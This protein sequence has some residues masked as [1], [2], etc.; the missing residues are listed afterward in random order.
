MHGLLGVEEQQD[1]RPEQD[2]ELKDDADAV[3]QAS[4]PHAGADHDPGDE[5]QDDRDDDRIPRAERDAGE[6]PAEDDVDDDA[7]ERL[8][9]DHARGVE[10]GGQP[11]PPFA[12][13]VFRPL[14]DAA[15]NRVLRDQFAELQ[16]HHGLE[17]QADR[18]HPDERWPAHGERCGGHQDRSG[19]R[20]L[21]RDAEERLLQQV[22][23]ALELWLDAEFAQVGV[24]LDVL[25]RVGGCLPGCLLVHCCAP[26]RA[27]GSR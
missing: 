14:V 3:E 9:D 6:E 4:Q 25:G 24:V 2:D 5:R 12:A 19:G 21:E 26:H 20:A 8:D 17:D 11:A 27:A 22:E 23:P 15:G 1:R 7:E 10:D 13:Q 16:G 18:E